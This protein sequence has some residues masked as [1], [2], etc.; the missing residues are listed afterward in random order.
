M[1]VARKPPAPPST[2]IG[3]E[4][5][6]PI[7][8][9]L[10]DPIRHRIVSILGESPGGM[11]VSTLCGRIDMNQPS[12]SHHLALL[13]LSGVV[14]CERRGKFNVYNVVP[15]VTDKLARYFAAYSHA[16]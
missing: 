5:V 9:V 4:E 13:R 12:V 15:G 8:N 3:Y 16:G 1:P 6:H 11:N 14:E 10:A 7:V 2:R